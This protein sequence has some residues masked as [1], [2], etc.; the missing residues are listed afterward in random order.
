[1]SWKNNEIDF[2][3]L[4]NHFGK[5]YP[6]L[7]EFE[8]TNQ[9]NEWH[10]EGDVAIHTDMVIKESLKIVNKDCPQYHD[11]MILGAL[12]HDIFKPVTTKEKELRG[13]QRIVSPRHEEDGYNHL[14]YKFKE[15]KELSGIANEVLQIVGFHQTPK[16][17][18]VRDA[19][20]W[21]YLDAAIKF[22][23]DL[24]YH[25]SRADILGRESVDKSE[26]LD[27]IEMFKMQTEEY[28]F[29][30]KDFNDPILECFSKNNVD[31]KD[32]GFLHQKAM[33]HLIKGDIYDPIEILSKYYDEI[34]H[35][36]SQVFTMV[37]LSGSG[38]SSY[39]KDEFINCEI[40]SLDAI[41]DEFS[42][43][44]DRKYEGQVLQ[45]SKKR[46]TS[47][48]AKKNDVVYDATNIRKD[49]R[50]RV[51]THTIN[52][53]SYYKPILMETTLSE[54]IENDKK[55]K[56]SIGEELIRKQANNFQHP[57]FD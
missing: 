13:Q 6:L 51:L 18:V 45:E 40:V 12:F 16:L 26:Q 56:F 43:N 34:N 36:Y 55:R 29:W 22:N 23:T 2:K 32:W 47:H 7:N 30:G 49:F 1:M 27:Y 31:R 37:G 38:K 35:G 33:Y 52:Y 53:N 41:R 11:Q 28:G 57:I 19:N 4:R 20:K 25:F 24:L 8:S 3:N 39:I 10:A 17:L 14:F 42:K 44:R 48:L 15:D 46:L 54:C 9:D 21:Q 50:Q 5:K